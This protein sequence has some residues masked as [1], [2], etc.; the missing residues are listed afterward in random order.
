MPRLVFGVGI[1]DADYA[2]QPKINGVQVCCLFYRK[3]KNMLERCYYPK[4][5]VKHPTYQG[6]VVCD[7]WIYFSNFKE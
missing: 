1:N 2:V 4:E 6:C 3:W 5:L 7:E